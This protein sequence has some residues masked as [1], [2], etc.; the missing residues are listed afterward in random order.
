MVM[1]RKLRLLQMAEL[2]LLMSNRDLRGWGCV[3]ISAP[4]LKHSV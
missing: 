4:G 1:K 3:P 2:P